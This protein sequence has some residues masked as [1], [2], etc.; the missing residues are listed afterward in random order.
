[1]S[2]FHVNETNLDE[3][4]QTASTKHEGELAKLLHPLEEIK[5]DVVAKAH[6]RL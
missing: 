3:A 6:L 1:M 2:K 4:S 5:K